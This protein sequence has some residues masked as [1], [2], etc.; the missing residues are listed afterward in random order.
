MF[1]IA[2]TRFNESTWQENI[3]YRIK[4]SIK[5]AIYGVSIKIYE[6]YPLNSI[7]F[8]IEMNNDINK[9][10]GIG[11]IRNSLSFDKKYKIYNESNY[12]RFIYKGDYWLSRDDILSCD[13]ALVTMFENMLF[14]KKS[15]LK[16]LSGISFLT[17]KIYLNW[18]YN[19]RD[20]RE[21]I[22]NIFISKFKQQNL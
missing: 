20:I 5:G 11:I 8:V 14:K 10:C 19:E 2:S 15:N 4:N 6:K 13:E 18:K 9:I 12:N 21:S 16:R 1:F 3:N 7:I 17:S 22:K